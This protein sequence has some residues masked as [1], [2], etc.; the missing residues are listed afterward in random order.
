MIN[1]KIASALI[2]LLETIDGDNTQHPDWIDAVCTA[3]EQLP[4]DTLEALKDTVQTS[5]E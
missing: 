4:E 2:A 1:P 5:V 3:R